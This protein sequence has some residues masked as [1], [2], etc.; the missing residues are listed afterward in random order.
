[1]YNND[2]DMYYNEYDDEDYQMHISKSKDIILNKYGEGFLSNFI[3]KLNYHNNNKSNNNYNN[4]NNECNN[5]NYHNDSYCKKHF[6]HIHKKSQMINLLKYVKFILKYWNIY[7]LIN[8]KNLEEYLLI[9][10]FANHFNFFQNMI[11]YKIIL[12]L[13]IHNNLQKA[14]ELLGNKS[15]VWNWY[16]NTGKIKTNIEEYLIKDISCKLFFTNNKQDQLLKKLNKFQYKNKYDQ[17]NFFLKNYYHNKYNHNYISSVYIQYLHFLK[18]KNTHKN[19][20]SKNQ[21]TKEYDIIINNKK[22][23]ENVNNYNHSININQTEI[24][25][26]KYVNHHKYFTHNNITQ[27]NSYI[28]NN[29]N[30][31]ESYEKKRQTTDYIPQDEYNQLPLFFLSLLDLYKNTF[32]VY[33]FYYQ[34]VIYKLLKNNN[35]HNINEIQNYVEDMNK[36]LKNKLAS[37]DLYMMLYYYQFFTFQS[38]CNPNQNVLNKNEQNLIVYM[39]VKHTQG[40]LKKYR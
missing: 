8:E 16:R 21:R 9:L 24:N 13:F 5:N 33:E 14:D 10:F 22:T 27:D 38:I 19:N 31:S 32:D 30:N 17:N 6:R 3:N 36:Y 18:Y 35:E 15:M 39:W 34:S 26:N 20:Y 4:N 28:I 23:E 12:K 40:L 11:K 29:N 2:K 25:N 7:N 37:Y 1:M